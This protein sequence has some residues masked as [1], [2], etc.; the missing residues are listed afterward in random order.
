M[1]QRAFHRLVGPVVLPS[2]LSATGLTVTFTARDGTYKMLAVSK[3]PLLKYSGPDKQTPPFSP[4]VQGLLN[5]HFF[6]SQCI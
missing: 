4:S 6:V 5:Q 2:C 1:E 3:I